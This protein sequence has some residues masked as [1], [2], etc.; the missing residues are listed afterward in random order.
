MCRHIF[1]RARAAAGDVDASRRFQCS[2]ARAQLRCASGD[3]QAIERASEGCGLRSIIR[4]R[5]YARAH[6]RSEDTRARRRR[7]TMTATAATVAA[8]D[9]RAHARALAIVARCACNT[10]AHFLNH[11]LSAAVSKRA[12]ERR[13]AT[14]T[15]DDDGD[16]Q[17]W[18]RQAT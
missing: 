14:T 9:K 17:R 4:C 2:I 10:T 16:K 11:Q 6:M 18:R 13:Q 7:A 5:L 12:N 15:R 8:S 1:L 3:E